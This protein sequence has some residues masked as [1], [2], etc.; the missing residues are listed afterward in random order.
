M[1]VRQA[2]GQSG[3]LSLGFDP[4]EKPAAVS[5][6]CFASGSNQNAGNCITGRS[7]TR[8]HHAPGGYSTLSLA[9]ESVSHGKV[10]TGAAADAPVLGGR[11]DEAAGGHT[12]SASSNAFANSSNQNAGNVLTERS[13]T[14]LQ[15]APGG[16]SSVCLSHDSAVGAPS[17]ASSN[18]FANSS[19]QNAGNVLTERSSTRL[20]QAPGGTS[21]VC[22]SHDAP[23][24]PV[25]LGAKKDSQ[26]E[27]T[28]R[29]LQLCC[30]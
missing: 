27:H 20:H 15:Q 25:I 14:R 17:H 30:Q 8:L 23:A 29:K 13:S 12:L 21:S 10:V 5:S 1:A 9:H 2:A 3:S 4:S 22:L 11:P 7:S 16:T 26:Y 19:N 24:S 28:S 6:N 18:A